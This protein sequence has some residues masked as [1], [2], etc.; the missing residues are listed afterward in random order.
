LQTPLARTT[1]CRSQLSLL[2]SESNFKLAQWTEKGLMGKVLHFAEMVHAPEYP[3][4][5]RTREPHKE[6]N[7]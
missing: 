5:T 6:Y 3:A 1:A 4:A 7:E 2:H